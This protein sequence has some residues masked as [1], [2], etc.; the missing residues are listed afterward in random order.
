[1]EKCIN[2]ITFS[3]DSK[4][5]E[6]C[7][8]LL[9]N[10]AGDSTKGRDY[11]LQAGALTPLINL[12]SNERLIIVREST[13]AL[14][15]LCQGNPDLLSPGIVLVDLIIIGSNTCSARIAELQG[16]WSS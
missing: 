3:K 1:V 9:A 4:L 14:S 2:L 6:D 7:I 11:V 12:L 15:N 10:V 5:I 16:F 13:W 8:C